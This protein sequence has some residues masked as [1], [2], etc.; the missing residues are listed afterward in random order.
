MALWSVLVIK[1][2]PNATV[3]YFMAIETWTATVRLF[4]MLTN[5]SVKPGHIISASVARR[6]S[7]KQK[8]P[9]V[10]VSLNKPTTEAALHTCV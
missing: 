6:S 3:Y 4:A 9:T 7:T 1:F 5:G 8:E 2:P 10:V